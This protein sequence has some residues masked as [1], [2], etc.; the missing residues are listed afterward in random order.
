MHYYLF[1]KNSSQGQVNNP[2]EKV[3]CTLNFGFDPG[4]GKM[5]ARATITDH[6]VFFLEDAQVYA[7]NDVGLYLK[8]KEHDDSGIYDQEWICAYDEKMNEEKI[9]MEMTRSD[10]FDGM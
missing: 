2:N 7:V 1:R 8:G 6:E 4:H 9:N 3:R 5:T 10:L